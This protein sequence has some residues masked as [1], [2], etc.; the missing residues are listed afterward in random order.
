MSYTESAYA[1][2]DQSESDQWERLEHYQ[3]L[4]DY[5]QDLEIALAQAENTTD[6]H[7]AE[8]DLARADVNRLM[9]VAEI[10][11]QDGLRAKRDF[12]QQEEDQERRHQ[13][14]I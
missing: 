14:S 5:A 6:V 13:V 12:Q 7:L 11:R 9:N 2:A 3:F 8:R 4:A 1:S 10:L